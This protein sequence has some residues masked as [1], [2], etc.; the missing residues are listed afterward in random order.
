MKLYILVRSDLSPG[1]QIAQAIHAARQFAAEHPEI[2]RCWF[3]QSNTVVCLGVDN[4]EALMGYAQLAMKNGL[5]F[6]IFREPDFENEITALALEPC[7][8]SQEICK[9]LPLALRN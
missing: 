3:E 4:E 6:S 7:F 9:D 5:K 2:E 1:R 8:R